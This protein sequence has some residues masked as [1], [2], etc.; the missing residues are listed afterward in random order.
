MLGSIHCHVWPRAR[1]FPSQKL[2]LRHCMRQISQSPP[3]HQ[4]GGLPH[5]GDEVKDLARVLRIRDQCRR[6]GL[7]HQ[8]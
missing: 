1:R 7:G 8:Y 6:Q 4:D 5:M 2:P 3:D